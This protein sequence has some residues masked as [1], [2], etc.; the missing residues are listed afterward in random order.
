[1]HMFDQD[2]SLTQQGDGEFKANISGNWSIDGNPNGGYLMALLLN[3]MTQCRKTKGIPIITANFVARSEVGPADVFVE[4]ISRS[5]RFNRLEARLVQKGRERIRALGTFMK[6]SGDR[7]EKHYGEH[8]PVI[9]DPEESVTVPTLP[10]YTLYEMM[11]VRLDPTTAGW[12]TGTLTEKSDVKGWI[13]FKKKRQFDALAVVLIADS[14]PPAVLSSHGI[15]GWIPTIEFSVSV[16]SI[17][18]GEWLKCV[19][20]TSFIHNGM[21]EEDGYIWDE[22]GSLIAVS[23]QHAWLRPSR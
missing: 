18:G 4:H 23:R 2:V 13:R 10:K 17:P 20:K 14:F 8:E 1:M 5:N 12:M 19:F 3:A 22:A 9:A 11:D 7:G 16:R 21:L 6:E 15:V